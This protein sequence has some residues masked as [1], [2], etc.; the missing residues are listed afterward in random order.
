MFIRIPI[1]GVL[2]IIKVLA[3]GAI[4]AKVFCECLTKTP[5]AEFQTLVTSASW[6]RH[7]NRHV[8]HRRRPRI[9]GAD[10]CV[11]NC[12]IA[13]PNWRTERDRGRLETR[14]AS[15]LRAGAD[16]PR[17]RRGAQAR[18]CAY[19]RI[20]GA[21]RR[22]RASATAGKFPRQY[23]RRNPRQTR[24]A[25]LGANGA[26]ASAIVI[27]NAARRLPH[28]RLRARV[29]RLMHRLRAGS[30]MCSARFD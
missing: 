9:N 17:P 21:T 13:W 20:A 6:V 24:P 12:L 4:C 19:R 3:D 26:L 14:A 28:S 18:Q 7:G 10:R 8:G 25:K 11:R 1:T 2:S 29:F 23:A 27:H 5:N 15:H 30:R 22:R 16:S